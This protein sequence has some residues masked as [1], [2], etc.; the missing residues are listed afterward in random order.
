MW[1]RTFI[2]LFL[3]LLLNVSFMLNL[4]YMTPLPRDI[5]LLIGFVGGFLLWGGIATYYY[6]VESIKLPLI[7]G[8]IVLAASAG[9]NSLFALGLV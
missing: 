6:C 7:K 4:A 1:A 9:I 8:L 3:G 2:A 5:Y